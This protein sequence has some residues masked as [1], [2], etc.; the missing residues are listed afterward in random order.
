MFSK[1]VTGLLLLMASIAIIGV[2]LSVSITTTQT[3]KKA[4]QSK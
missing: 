3:K 1:G 4:S 2:V